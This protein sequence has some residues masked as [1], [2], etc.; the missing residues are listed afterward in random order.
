MVVSDPFQPKDDGSRVVRLRPR[1]DGSRASRSG[2]Q[3]MGYSEPDHS[4]VPDLA[5]YHAPESEDA[6]RHRMIAN[7]I[8]L[9]FTSL[10]ILAGV[11]LAMMVVRA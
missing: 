8:A 5:K 1:M 2:K 6:Y 3:L 9:L 11:C 7:L 10:L 4:P